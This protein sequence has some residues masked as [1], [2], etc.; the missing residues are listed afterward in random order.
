[1]WTECDSRLFQSF[2]YALTKTDP[3]PPCTLWIVRYCIPYWAFETNNFELKFCCT[4]DFRFHRRYDS[5][6]KVFS[7]EYYN[8]DAIFQARKDAITTAPRAKKF[9]LILSTLGRQGSSKVLEVL[10]TVK[11]ENF[12]SKYTF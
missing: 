6:S 5:S 1:M 9:R 2:P 4:F 10:Y 8:I 11:C 7:R 3:L 12:M